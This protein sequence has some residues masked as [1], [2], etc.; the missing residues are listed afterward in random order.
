ME[1]SMEITFVAGDISDRLIPI[2]TRPPAEGVCCL[3]DLAAS[4]RELGLEV[5]IEPL[6]RRR[7]RVTMRYPFE[8]RAK[9]AR[10][11]H[12]GRRVRYNPYESPVFDCDTT[13]A[14]ALAWLDDHGVAEGM[15]ALCCSSRSTYFRWLSRLRR[16]VEADAAYNERRV[17]AGWSPQPAGLE[18]A[19]A[20]D[21]DY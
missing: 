5:E 9:A 17:A 6:P 20:R 11:R 4:L 12:A 8:H 1:N 2:G 18:S 13:A 16:N 3:E 14:D 15:R 7:A 19:L 21:F 10:T